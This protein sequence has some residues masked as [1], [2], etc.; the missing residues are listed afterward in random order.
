MWAQKKDRHTRLGGMAV[1]GLPTNP[2]DF[3]GFF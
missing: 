3:G 1:L 2:T